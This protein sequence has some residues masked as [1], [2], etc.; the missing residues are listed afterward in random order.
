[1]SNVAIGPTYRTPGPGRVPAGT[2]PLDVP[3]SLFDCNSESSM[4]SV[5]MHQKCDS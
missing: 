3:A 5:K 2:P 1:M 4:N